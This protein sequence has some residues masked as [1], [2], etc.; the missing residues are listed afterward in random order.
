V[1]P[2][3]NGY[4]LPCSE[5]KWAFKREKVGRY[6]T[7]QKIG[8]TFSKSQ[9][10]FGC[11]VF[12]SLLLWKLDSY[13]TALAVTDFLFLLF[14]FSMSWRHLPIIRTMWFYWYYTPF[15]LWITDAASS[16]S[17]LL[18]VAFTV[19]CYIGVCYPM[20]KK[21]YRLSITELGK[22]DVSTVRS[23][24]HNHCLRIFALGTF[25]RRVAPENDVEEK[26]DS[27]VKE[28]KNFS[29]HATCSHTKYV[30]PYILRL[31]QAS[32]AENGITVKLIAVVI[33]FLICQMPTALVLIYTSIHIPE[34]GTKEDSV[35]LGLGNIFNLLVTINAAS[36]I[37]LYT[38][39]CSTYRKHFSV[40]VYSWKW[41]LV[42]NRC[43]IRIQFCG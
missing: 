1:R 24:V 30:K 12:Y 18:T 39:L 8:T 2:I 13:L 40:L 33:L 42:G 25:G 22:Q 28:N 23:L 41:S 38:A 10:A 7:K 43:A 16:S 26:L 34:P 32:R 19:E 36:N 15:G 5:G 20:K 27:G 35:L 31:K 17:V 4:L 14:S 21:L 3:L 9:V 6:W 11:S 29:N 37:L